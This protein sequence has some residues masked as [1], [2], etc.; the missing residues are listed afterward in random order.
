M[1]RALS[2]QDVYLVPR[3]SESESRSK[4]DVSV[5]FLGRRFRL[6]IVTSNMESVINTDIAKWLSENN[7]FYIMHRF[8][9]TRAFVERANRE[10]WKTISISI[11][12]KQS[13]IDI[14]Y[15]IKSGL[16]ITHITIDVANGHHLAV[17][18]TIEHIKN[19]YFILAPHFGKTKIIPKIIA[20]NVATPEAV[21]DLTAWGADAIKVGTAGGLCCSTKNKTGFHVPMFTCA[22]ECCKSSTIPIILDGGIRENGDIAKALNAGATL[23]MAGSIFAACKD[24]PGDNITTESMSNVTHKKYHGSASFKQKGENRHIEGESIEVPCNGLTIEEK[25]DE[26]KESL[27]SSV[28]YAGGTNLDALKEVKYITL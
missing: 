1:N 11:G 3:Y 19:M 22:L 18:R 4:A 23:V 8:G 10:K 24:A 15:F 2:Y 16:E 20:G 27:Q 25:M 14:D 21:K 9:D 26:I 6:P 5:E 13:D 17:R 28:S 12:V 7:L